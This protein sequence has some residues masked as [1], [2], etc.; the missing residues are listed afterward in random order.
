MKP[1][2]IR[3]WALG[4]T[5]TASLWCAKMNPPYQLPA[6]VEFKADLVYASPNGHALHLDLFAPKGAGPFPAV[7]YVHGG[8]FSAGNKIAFWRQ[9]AYMATKGFV[10]VSIEY[11][12][13]QEARYPAALNDCKAA[14]RWLRANA[15]LYHVDPARIGAAGGSAGGH[16]VAMLGTTADI[17][18]LEG[19]EG[20]AKF[21]SRVRAVAA[22]NPAVDFVSAGKSGPADSKSS[23]S[24]FL[25]ATYEENPKV[26]EEATPLMRVSKQSAAFLFLHGT[27]DTTVPFQASVDMLNRLKKAGAVAE[28]FPADGANHGFFQ[29]PPFFEPAMLRM[30]AFF[31]KY[32]H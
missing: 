20:N 25:G 11:R 32:L 23:I 26:W 28:I 2:F 10:G 21:S 7:V 4:I 19:D 13:S 24:S 22:F 8:G 9:A 31:E 30:E 29:S 14:V 1:M 15:A 5:L 6:G 12:L 16:L 3:L 18:A 17:P 27:A